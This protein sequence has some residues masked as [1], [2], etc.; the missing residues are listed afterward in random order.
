MQPVCSMSH[1]DGLQARS[2]W[3]TLI[4]FGHPTPSLSLIHS[5]PELLKNSLDPLEEK[6]SMSESIIHWP[7]DAMLL[8]SFLI[9]LQ[10]SYTSPSGSYWT[11]NLFSSSSENL[12]SRQYLVNSF[13]IKYTMAVLWHLNHTSKGYLLFNK[14]HKT[15]NSRTESTFNFFFIGIP[16]P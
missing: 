9:F 10:K 1:K 16:H 7:H 14:D 12:F 11:S 5:L 15:V 3:V 8:P 6:S 2:G 13:T 4:T